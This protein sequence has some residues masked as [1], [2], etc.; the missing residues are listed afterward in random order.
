MMTCLE[1]EHAECD[2][3][4]TGHA[5]RLHNPSGEIFCL[6][7]KSFVYDPATDAVRAHSAYDKRRRM[8]QTERDAE[9][10]EGPVVIP[11]GTLGLRGLVNLGNTC[12]MNSVLQ[13]VTRVPDLREYFL[14][15]RH[16]ETC[17]VIR[18]AMSRMAEEEG[19][20]S[21]NHLPG[22][23]ALP[24]TMSANGEGA[25]Q[26]ETQASRYLSSWARPWDEE[27]RRFI[28]G[29]NVGGKGVKP[30]TNAR[31]GSP[32]PPAAATTTN[33]TVPICF[34]CEVRSLASISPTSTR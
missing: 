24:S 14:S 22:G 34:G 2:S 10:R 9:G 33:V 29:S 25:Y 31:T 16:R 18:L 12:F 5:L 17:S 8:S 27:H 15:G 30:S 6:V 26:M 3:I 23:G 7:C 19:R 4:S 32:V 1:C 28:T 13:V 20:A 11:V 21:A